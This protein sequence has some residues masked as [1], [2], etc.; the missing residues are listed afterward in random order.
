MHHKKIFMVLMVVVFCA[1]S[2]V[3]ADSCNRDAIVNAVEWGVNIVN[4]KGEAAYNELREYK[5]CDGKGYISV[6]SMEGVTLCHPMRVLE[7]N[8]QTKNQGAKGTFFMV[9]MKQKAKMY[10]EG[11]ISYWWPD[12]TTG[13]LI[14]KCAY[15]KTAV[16]NGKEVFISSGLPGI[17]EDQC[18]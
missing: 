10:G 5:Y 6:T 11:W 13:D 9:E 4:E 16:I 18:K 17:P 7:G 12:K 8:D 1:T 3:Y 15:L 14:F 2:Q